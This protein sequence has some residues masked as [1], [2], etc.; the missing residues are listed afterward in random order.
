[1]EVPMP[2]DI[3]LGQP[4]VV[5]PDDPADSAQQAA[6][7]LAAFQAGRI[8]AA[9]CRAQLNTLAVRY[10]TSLSTWAA[11][12]ELTL[13]SDVIAAY[14]FFR[15]GYHR[16]LDRARGSGW[17]GTQQLR[18]EH[19]SNRGFLRC[20]YG[21]MRAATAIGEEAEAVRTRNFLLDLDPANHFEIGPA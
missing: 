3:P 5:L 19:E 6:E 18:W 21:L 7:A 16:G 12:G 11:L 15:T 9:I 8:D 14:A 10:P 20:L 4:F 1:M 2:I 17:R 13:P